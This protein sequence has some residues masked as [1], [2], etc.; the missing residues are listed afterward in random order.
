MVSW[1]LSSVSLDHQ[2][3]PL[4]VVVS[5]SFQFI[6]FLLTYILHTTHAAK[7][8]SRVGLGITLI[9]FGFGL[10]TK[11]EELI[12]TGHFPSETEDPSD[13]P[14]TDPIQQDE[15]AAEN[16]LKAYLGTNSPWPQPIR[17]PLLPPG[18]P[19][20]ILHNTHEAELYAI[21]HNTTLVELLGLPTAVDVGRANEYFSF[22]LMA[23]GWFLILTSLGGLWRV[24]RFERGLK[25]AQRESE[26]AQAAAAAQRDGTE[27]TVTSDADPITTSTSPS[28]DYTSL[29]YYTRGFRD[30]LQGASEIRR[31]FFGMRGRPV[32]GQNGHAPLAQDDEHELLDAQGFGL[33]P[34]AA[35][36]DEARSPRRPRGL[37][38]V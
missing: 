29:S 33:E 11:A 34:M 27:P 13:P 15:I 37:W 20:V 6:G 19:P 30:A 22:L 17:D 7:Y 1:E 32:G 31:G 12:R 26:A 14:I 3:T 36:G 18:S 21:R 5:F 9:Q 35:S 8:G 23:V 2:L 38:G 10:R 16:A 4:T 25:A 24:K 28:N